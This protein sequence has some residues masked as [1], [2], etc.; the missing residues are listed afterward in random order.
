MESNV[1][2]ATSL[3]FR[4]GVVKLIPLDDAPDFDEMQKL[5]SKEKI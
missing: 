5:T 2:S 3:S 1:V 4:E